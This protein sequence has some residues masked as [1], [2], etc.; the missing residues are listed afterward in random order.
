LSLNPSPCVGL[1]KPAIFLALDRW[2]K[3]HPLP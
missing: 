3:E 2:I 1:R